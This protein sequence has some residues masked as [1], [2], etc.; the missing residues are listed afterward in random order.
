MPDEA[1][2]TVVA[3][4]G[5]L[6]IHNIDDLR[7]EIIGA[8]YDS[9]VVIA[10]LSGVSYIDSSTVAVL[11]G[12]TNDMRSKRGELRVVAPAGGRAR[13]ILEVSGVDS[14]LSLYETLDDAFDG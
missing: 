11:L 14:T 1:T 7:L 6:D 10:D 8:A 9:D 12:T 5:E 2:A 4:T 3:P 13:R